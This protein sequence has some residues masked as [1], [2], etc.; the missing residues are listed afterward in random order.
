MADSE[1]EGLVDR[2]NSRI[3]EIAAAQKGLKRASVLPVIERRSLA[4][5]LSQAQA[6]LEELRSGLAGGTAPQTSTETVAEAGEAPGGRLAEVESALGEA[7]AVLARVA[8]ATHPAARSTGSRA[9][10]RPG[11][12]RG[13]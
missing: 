6:R 8:E 7:E 2:V 1:T 10:W 3:E 13:W 9:G 5:K 4:A 11:E 12:R